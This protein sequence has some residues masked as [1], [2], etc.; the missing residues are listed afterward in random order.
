MR[1]LYVCTF[2]LESFIDEE[3]PPYAILSHTW[4]TEEIALQELL[5][6]ETVALLH[7]AKIR[8]KAGV[9]HGNREFKQGFLKM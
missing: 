2:K 9:M 3:C 4:G 7:A 5:L 1:L 8:L 6:E